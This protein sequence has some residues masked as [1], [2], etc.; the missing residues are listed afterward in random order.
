MN[1]DVWKDSDEFRFTANNK[2]KGL[3]SFVEG[4][5]KN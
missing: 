2:T 1:V 3:E 5:G 4:T